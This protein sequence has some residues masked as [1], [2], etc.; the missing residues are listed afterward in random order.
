MKPIEF[1]KDNAQLRERMEYW[2]PI[3]GLSDWEIAVKLA[4]KEEMAHP[5]YAGQCSSDH[6]L[7]S[8][9]ILIRND[10]KETA[11]DSYFKQYQEQVLIHELLHCKLL[12]FED[13]CYE[14]A[15]CETYHHGFIEDMAKA[16][17]YAKYNMSKEDMRK[18]LPK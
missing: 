14:E 18:E 12:L 16:I 2:I 7:K 4:S 3:L 17:F 8:A 10:A 15:V 1:F 6:I 11:K 13:K 9:V 5:N